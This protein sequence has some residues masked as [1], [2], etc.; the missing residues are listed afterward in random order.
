V[1]KHINEIKLP[2]A[3][4]AMLHQAEKRGFGPT[5][6]DF[7]PGD[8]VQGLLSVSHIKCGV[9]HDTSAVTYM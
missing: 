9:E 2:L 4:M 7:V 8:Y 5:A 1:R 3:N 6:G